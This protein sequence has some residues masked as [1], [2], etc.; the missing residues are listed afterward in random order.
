MDYELLSESRNLISNGE[1]GWGRGEGGP[2]KSNGGGDG[3]FFEKIEV[4]E[5]LIRDSRVV[6]SYGVKC[7]IS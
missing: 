3:D 5:T 4:G 6:K 1:R 7:Q 2:N